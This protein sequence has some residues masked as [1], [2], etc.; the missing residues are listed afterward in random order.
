MTF[1]EKIVVLRKSHNLSQ[2][3]LAKRVGV[4]LRTVRGWEIENRY[5]KT[6]EIYLRL[7]DTL[8]CS[9]AYL[10]GEESITGQT[11]E[12]SI[13]DDVQARRLASELSGLFAGGELDPAD[14]DEMMRAIQDAYWISKGKAKTAR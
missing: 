11:P 4:S 13:P 3:E 10:M 1:G 12:G 6:K 14:V 5:P 9:L 7:A 2:T 8:E